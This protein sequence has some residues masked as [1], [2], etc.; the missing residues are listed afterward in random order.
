MTDTNGEKCGQCGWPVD[1]ECDC[2]EDGMDVREALEGL[3]YG[4]T[5][6]GVDQDLATDLAPRVEAA[7]RAGV[8]TEGQ[9]SFAW[10]WRRKSKSGWSEWQLELQELHANAA[11]EVW[12]ADEV[13][14]QPLFTHPK[15]VTQREGLAQVMF[16]W[17]FL[18]HGAC[19]FCGR[20]VGHESDCQWDRLHAKEESD[21]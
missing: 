15:R 4:P 20:S 12:G 7:L 16:D 6:S 9:P 5:H 2:R 11:V 18:Y 8:Q 17:L 13:E 21:G 1:A 14:V 19:Y 3:I 10:A